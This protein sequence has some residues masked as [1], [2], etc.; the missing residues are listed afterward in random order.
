MFRILRTWAFLKSS[1][2][3]R[4]KNKVKIYSILFFHLMVVSKNDDTGC[5]LVQWP[6]LQNLVLPEISPWFGIVLYR[7]WVGE[8]QC[9][10]VHE[11]FILI[12][13]YSI[14]NPYASFPPLYFTQHLTVFWFV[15]RFSCYTF[16]LLFPHTR[17]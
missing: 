15:T 16:S 3:F 12:H 1:K 7:C 14:E 10:L 13:F 4:I 17:I 9:Y 11:S 6:L 2:Y 5:F 8:F